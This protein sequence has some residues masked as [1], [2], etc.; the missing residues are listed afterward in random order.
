MKVVY[1]Q[2]KKELLDQIKDVSTEEKGLCYLS[3]GIYK[4]MI[5]YAR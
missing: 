5:P 4:K 3:Y 1:L 2:W